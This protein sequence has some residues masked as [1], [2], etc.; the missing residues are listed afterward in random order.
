MGARRH[1]VQASRAFQSVLQLSPNYRMARYAL[2]KSINTDD[3]S[4]C[5]KLN[6]L[7]TSLKP[8]LVGIREGTVTSTAGIDIFA[9]LPDLVGHV[10]NRFP[11]SIHPFDSDDA[12]YQC[13]T[14]GCSHFQDTFSP[15][16]SCDPPPNSLA[17]DQCIGFVVLA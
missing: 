15:P 13:I 12:L 14:S 16:C 4:A 5:Q 11:Y 6:G 2:G 17:L 9:L 1:A 7:T 10:A 8:S 3:A